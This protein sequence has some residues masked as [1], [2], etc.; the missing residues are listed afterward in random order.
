MR[1]GKSYSEEVRQFALSLYSCSPKGYEFLRSKLPLPSSR[2][3]RRWLASV[4]GRPGCF[5]EA[6]DFLSAKFKENP[7]LYGQCSLMVDGMS[8]RKFVSW[9]P[10][11]RSNVGFVDMGFGPIESRGVATEA[12][13]F[14][15]VGLCG[16]YELPVGYVLINSK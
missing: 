13:V 14:H 9:D 10:A 2:T 7:F 8:I 12:L 11:S 6:A 16:K 4:D 5:S 3:L 1:D 15:C